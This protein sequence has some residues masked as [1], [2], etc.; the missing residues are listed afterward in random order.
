MIFFDAHV[1]FYK[2]FELDVL[3][4]SFASHADIFA[5][6]ADVLAMAV[7]LR[8]FQPSL[9]SVFEPFK[10]R[11]LRG[12]TIEESEEHCFSATDGR[13]RIFI[14]PAR[15]VAAKERV[16]ALG[17]FGEAEV[18]DG[19]PLD[20]TITRLRDAGYQPVIA[21]GLGKWLFKRRPVVASAL[22]AAGK[23]GKPL[24]VC[25]CALRPT[26]WPTPQLY[27]K[28]IGLGGFVLYGSDPL[29]RIGD[30]Y[31]AGSYATLID[32]PFDETVPASSIL[33][34]VRTAPL[35]PVGRRYGLAGTLKRLH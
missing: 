19:L 14:L 32:A 23:A 34:A 35:T 4:T 13:H 16:E 2:Q 25:D 29:P 22:E 30:E 7:M 33:S 26:F 9:D 11:D 24:P 5:R 21:W 3:L 8:G 1:H 31:S 17:Y 18:P 6:D 10:G 15:Q 20:E 28:A 12:W 27:K